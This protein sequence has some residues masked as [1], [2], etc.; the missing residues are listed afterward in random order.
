MGFCSAPKLHNSSRSQAATSRILL[1]HEGPRRTPCGK[2]LGCVA[3][4]A[5]FKSCDD[6]FDLTFHLRVHHCFRVILYLQ[7]PWLLPTH[8]QQTHQC[9]KRPSGHPGNAARTAVQTT[10]NPAPMCDG[11]DRGETDAP[12]TAYPRWITHPRAND[13]SSTPS[14][15]NRVTKQP[16]STCESLRDLVFA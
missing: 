3:L 10:S 15:C 14:F 11:H 5:G 4:F 12:W 16:R 6:G 2:H 9:D 7:V 8:R 13:E 1:G